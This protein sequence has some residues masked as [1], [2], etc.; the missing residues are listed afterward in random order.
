MGAGIGLVEIQQERD[1][2]HKALL[3]RALWDG[4]FGWRYGFKEV[5][6]E[7]VTGNGPSEGVVLLSWL[8]WPVRGLGEIDSEMGALCLFR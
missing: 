7:S 3:E 6:M 1:N 4:D 2:D 8:W 5:S